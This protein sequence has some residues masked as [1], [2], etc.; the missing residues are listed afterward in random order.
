MRVLVTWGSKRGGTAGIG[1]ALADALAEH[2]MDVVAAPAE[3]APAP[4]GFDAAIVGGAVYANRWTASARRFVHRHLDAL[5]RIPVWFFSSGP[6]DD[7]ADRG[8]VDEPMAIAVLAERAGARGHVIF[9]GRLEPGARGLAAAMAR[10]HA[11]DWRSP[12]RIR[13]FADRVAAELPMAR[14]GRFVDHPARAPSRLLAHG[15]V[16]WMG[17]AAVLAALLELA[18]ED[19]ALAGRAVVAAPLFGFIAW[20]YSGGRGA[21]APLA[22]A[23]TWTVLVL[24]LDLVIVWAVAYRSLTLVGSVA[25]TWL[26][27][28]L[29]F[30][31]TWAVG[32]TRE[33]MPARR[34]PPAA[35][36]PLVTRRP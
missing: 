12:R 34:R 10:T 7:S 4:A 22:T 11:G 24:G 2:G 29:I 26:P 15:L 31:V 17:L 6:L 8:E 21:R 5:R 32:V 27:L 28:A 16:G 3:E 13:A 1:R 36:G 18:G 9:G 25:A 14:P 19:A 20:R 23:A 35:S 33:M 30:V